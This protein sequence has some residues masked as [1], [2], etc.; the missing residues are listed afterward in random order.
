[1]TGIVSLFHAATVGAS[2]PLL[3]PVIVAVAWTVGLL[4]TG[5][6]LQARWDRVFA[7]LL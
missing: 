3:V 4:I 6:L 2:G 7:D 5:T 1:M